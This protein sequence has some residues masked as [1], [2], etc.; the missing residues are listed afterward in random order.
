VRTLLDVERWQRV[1]FDDQVALIE[2]KWRAYQA[3]IV[4]LEEDGA[5]KV[6]QQ[7]MRRNTAVPVVPHAASNKTNLS[8]GVPGLLI[9]LE[10]GRW[11]FPY[12]VG[13]Y[14]RE[15]M[16]V[17][18]SEAESFGWVDGKLQGVGEHDD[19]VMTW[20]HL[21]WGIDRLQFMAT[22]LTGRIGTQPG[23]YL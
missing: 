8:A 4:V 7:H 23:R 12:K 5:Q 13:S 21:S 9:A 16:D 14:H 11:K 15:E 6:W 22:R 19:T 2:A 17:F 10:N 18:L 20:W 3:D 1:S